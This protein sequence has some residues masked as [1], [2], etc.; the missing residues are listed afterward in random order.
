MLDLRGETYLRVLPMPL[1]A[2]HESGLSEVPV[3]L[4]RLWQRSLEEECLG[5][6]SKYHFNGQDTPGSLGFLSLV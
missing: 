2:T 5:Q 4:S 1:V 3:H 6:G